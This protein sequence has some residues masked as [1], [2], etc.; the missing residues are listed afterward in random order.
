M[1]NGSM[2]IVGVGG[3]A[4]KVDKSGRACGIEFAHKAAHDDVLVTASEYMPDIDIA[5]PRRYLVRPAAG[6]EAHIIFD[7]SPAGA[8]RVE[9]FKGPTVATNG[10]ALLHMRHNFGSAKETASVMYHTPSLTDNGTKVFDQR[11]IGSTTG[12]V[13]SRIGGNMH[14][15]AELIA[16]NASPILM[17]ITAEADNLKFSIAGEYYEVAV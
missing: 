13:N 3:E 1:S 17:V 4:M 10:T 8:C 16:T 15:G 9:I 12:N 11:I 7:L 2:Q 5:V 6:H 14:E